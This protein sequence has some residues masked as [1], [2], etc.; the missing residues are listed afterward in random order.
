MMRPNLLT[1]HIRWF[2]RRENGTMTR[3][4]VRTTRRG[5]GRI[6]YALIA[7]LVVLGIASAAQA[8]YTY[9]KKITIHH[10][11][12]GGTSNLSGFAVLINIVGDANLKGTS[13]AGHVQHTDGYDI[14]FKD[15]S[16]NQIAHQIEQYSSAGG[17]LLAWVKVPI[18]DY[19]TDTIIWIHYGNG[20]ISAPTENPAAVWVNYAGVWHMEENP[21]ASAPQMKDSTANANHGSAT[22]HSWNPWISSDRV[23]GQIGQALYFYDHGGSTKQIEVQ[24]DDSLDCTT[25]ITMQAWIK[26]YSI[27]EEER[28]ILKKYDTYKIDASR[29]YNITPD[30]YVYIEDEGWLAE[31]PPDPLTNNNWQHL[32]S[33]W[34][35]SDGVLR[36]YV[37]GL[38]RSTDETSK[39][40]PRIRVSDGVLRI[41]KKNSDHIVDE[42]RV[43]CSAR[44]AGWIGTE[45]NNQFSPS[46]F[47]SIGPEEGMASSYIITAGAGDHGS[48]SPSG[49]VTVSAGADQL[50]DFSPDAGYEVLGVTVD[51]SSVGSPV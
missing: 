38:E 29:S 15:A 13:F 6:T 1:T 11:K 2:N 24:D 36:I 35:S 48:I 51:G 20:A 40:D 30:G 26:P 31:H 23:Q 27:E 19:N 41:S 37:D 22:T 12:V 50:F 8:G 5:I 18:L 28:P 25:G 3:L 7:A 49:D 47:Y 4:P 39:S 42:V 17:T 33:T 43:S 21:T 9:K 34:D 45:Y 16:N 46:T 14:I 32:V 44:S 10:E